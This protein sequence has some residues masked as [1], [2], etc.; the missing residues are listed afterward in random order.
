MVLLGGESERRSIRFWAKEKREERIA[1]RGD[2]LLF[3]MIG[4]FFIMGGKVFLPG[5]VKVWPELME[6]EEVRGGCRV[7]VVLPRVRGR[8]IR[9]GHGVSRSHGTEGA[10]IV[11]IAMISEQ[12]QAPHNFK[13]VLAT[14]IDV[15]RW[16][17]C[18]VSK[19]WGKS[20][21]HLKSGK[22]E[23]STKDKEIA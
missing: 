23:S 18:L 12:I 8:G 4:W 13:V 16:N 19:A 14:C 22:N 5:G 20:L 3:P 15:K 7:V 17:P 10:R 1:P 9:Q 6:V 21:T 11:M 2:V